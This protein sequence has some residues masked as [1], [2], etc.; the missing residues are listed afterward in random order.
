[1][2]NWIKEEIK[3][4]QPPTLADVIQDI[5]ASQPQDSYYQKINNLKTAAKMLSFLTEN[6]IKDIF[7]LE[8]KIQSMYEQI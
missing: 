3:S 8:E 5:L 2:K 7:E 4:N 6:S 1:M